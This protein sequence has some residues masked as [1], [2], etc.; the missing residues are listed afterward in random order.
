MNNSLNSGSEN[1]NGT[2]R[3]LLAVLFDMARGDCHATVLRLARQTGLTRPQVEEVLARLDRRGLVD[4]ER[5]R[6]TM[7][8]L[9]TTMLMG[10]AAPRRVAS[11]A[12]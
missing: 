12:A 1:L 4:A 2:E 7:S 6:L 5:V 9:A 8:G 11:R 3:A 10:V